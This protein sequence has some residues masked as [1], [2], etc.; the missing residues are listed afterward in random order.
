ME[1]AL[2]KMESSYPERMN[3]LM[4]NQTHVE[5]KPTAKGAHTHAAKPRQCYLMAS[6]L[7]RHDICHGP[8]GR[9]YASD[10]IGPFDH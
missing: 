8:L 1:G 5:Y 2:K 9:H 6:Y 4:P 3:Y 10:R 7:L